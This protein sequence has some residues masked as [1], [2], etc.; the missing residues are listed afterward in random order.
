EDN[1]L[2]KYW[3]GLSLPGIGIHGTIAPA[4][5][6]H[7]QSHGCI[8]LHPDDIEALFAQMKRGETGRIIYVPLLLS[9]SEGRIFLEAHR[10]I[11]NKSDVSMVALERLAN[12]AMLSDRIDWT[13]AA[14]VLEQR[15]GVAR[16]V[17]LPS[18]PQ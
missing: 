1:P 2:G 3:L 10:D 16:D 4:S 14:E 9:E 12:D 18:Q 6:Y 11:Y 7:F 13:R 17:T 15:E 5:I 8:R